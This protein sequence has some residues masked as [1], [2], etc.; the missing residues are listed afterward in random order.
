MKTFKNIFD[1]LFSRIKVYRKICGGVWRKIHIITNPEW[2]GGNAL[3]RCVIWRCEDWTSTKKYWNEIIEVYGDENY[4]RAKK[5][6][7]FHFKYL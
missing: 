7:S 4:E 6:N 5:Y 1:F 3:E 2:F